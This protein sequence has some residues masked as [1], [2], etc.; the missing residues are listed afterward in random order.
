MTKNYEDAMTD[1]NE[2]TAEVLQEDAEQYF[3]PLDDRGVISLN[4]ADARSFLQGLL[5]RNMD[6]ISYEN[7]GYGALLNAQGKFLYDFFIVQADEAGQQFLLDC[8]KAWLPEI[9]DKLAEYKLRANVS[10]TDVSDQYGVM[11]VLGEQVSEDIDP[12]EREGFL[13]HYDF[14]HIFLDPR[15]ATMQARGICKRDGINEVLNS[16]GFQLADREDYEI[17]RLWLGL[18][19]PAVDMG[20]GRAYPVDFGFVEMGAIDFDKGCFVGQEVTARVQHRSA[21]RYAFYPITFDG[22]MPDKGADIMVGQKKSGT[23]C[24]GME[25]IG[26]ALLRIEDVERVDASEGDLFFSVGETI[27][28]VDEGAVFEEEGEELEEDASEE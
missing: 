1:A 27:I 21:R 6:A 10:I 23:F 22:E 2:Q 11:A 15:T 7:A 3:L 12:E 24:S 17:L 14:G 13:L 19:D 8:H 26:V 28:F 5:T 18:P 4:G 25:D 16:Y 9:M 20:S